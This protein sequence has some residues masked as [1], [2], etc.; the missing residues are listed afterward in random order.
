MFTI[1][2]RYGMYIAKK[3]F[4]TCVHEA[5]LVQIVVEINSLK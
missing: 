4:P 1:S 5:S 2:A 3:H